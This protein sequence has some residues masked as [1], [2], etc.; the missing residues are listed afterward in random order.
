[1]PQIKNTLP[2]F[3]YDSTVLPVQHNQHSV[4]NGLTH[5]CMHKDCMDSVNLNPDP[6][7]ASSRAC[8]RQVTG[9]PAKSKSSVSGSFGNL[10]GVHVNDEPTDCLE[11]GES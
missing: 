11:D 1:M 3:D 7:L 10:M 8:V 2:V 9:I 6:P 5:K 4:D